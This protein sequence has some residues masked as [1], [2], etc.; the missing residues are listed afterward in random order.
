MN[1]G[2]LSNIS[3]YRIVMSNLPKNA[4]VQSGCSSKINTD[5]STKNTMNINDLLENDEASNTPLAENSQLSGESGIYGGGGS[6]MSMS[7]TSSGASSFDNILKN[8]KQSL[9][10]KHT[11]SSLT[12]LNRVI[13]ALLVSMI[14]LTV[15]DYQILRVEIENISGENWH[16]LNSEKRTLLTVLLA[17]NVRSQV[18]I[19]NKLEYDKYQIVPLNRY[20]HRFEYL[21]RMLND[22]YEEMDTIQEFM[23]QQ[24]VDDDAGT[25]QLQSAFEY[26]PIKLFRLDD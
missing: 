17:S 24:R 13:V 22:Q 1:L 25:D 15:T 16:N 10:E 2:N 20:S 12:L 9:G 6:S 8:F 19:A 5:N 14:V 7:S 21:G 11:P 18:N 23:A 4:N 3:L 26:E